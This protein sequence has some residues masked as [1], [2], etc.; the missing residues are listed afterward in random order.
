MC[1]LEWFVAPG[2]RYTEA[3]KS[4]HVLVAEEECR[5]MP[6]CLQISLITSSLIFKACPEEQ[7][8]HYLPNRLLYPFTAKT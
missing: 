6:V 8:V 7:N 5:R 1:L 3:K 4:E 2:L